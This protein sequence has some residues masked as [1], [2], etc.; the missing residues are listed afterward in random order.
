MEINCGSGGEEEKRNLGPLPSDFFFLSFLIGL[1]GF[2]VGF[3]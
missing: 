2:D 1:D 3:T